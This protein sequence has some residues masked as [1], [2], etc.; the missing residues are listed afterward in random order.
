MEE[1]MMEIKIDKKGD[2]FIG[3]TYG[4]VYKFVR[5]YCP[6]AAD[7]YCCD[8]CPMFVEFGGTEINGQMA[9]FKCWNSGGMPEYVKVVNL[10]EY[11][12]YNKR[13]L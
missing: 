11:S 9:S 3:R 5:A 1:E 8:K 10:R 7:S 12:K 13:K 4:E 2:V 6:H